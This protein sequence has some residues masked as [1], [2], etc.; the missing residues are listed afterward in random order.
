MIDELRKAAIQAALNI[1]E[2]MFFTFLELVE[3]PKSPE[4]SEG[5]P[6]ET[7]D[8]FLLTEIPF[9]GD[10]DGALRLL[11]P[12]SLGESL[13]MNFLGFEDEVTEPQLLDMASELSNMICGNLFSHYDKTAVYVLGSPITEKLSYSEALT[14]LKNSDI[15]ME[16]ETEGQKLTL[17]LHIVPNIEKG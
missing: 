13:A 11:L 10:L 1:F 3:A 9:K 16:F 15:D 2:T 5:L 4:S 8:T 12:F 6:D 17:Q 14:R 7:S